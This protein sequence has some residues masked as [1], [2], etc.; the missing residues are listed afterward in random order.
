MNVWNM[1]CKKHNMKVTL[2]ANK[3]QAKATEIKIIFAMI[4]IP[5]T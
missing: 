1:S 3:M 5:L 4:S 2:P